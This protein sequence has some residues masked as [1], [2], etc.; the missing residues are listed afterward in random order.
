MPLRRPKKFANYSTFY[1]RLVQVNSVPNN[2]NLGDNGS[3]NGE[4]VQPLPF[5]SSDA[6]EFVLPSDAEK[7][8][9]HEHNEHEEHNA[10]AVQEIVSETRP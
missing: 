1:R 9:E 2:I 4:N 6:E 5:Q 7:H 8:D 10:D 3:A